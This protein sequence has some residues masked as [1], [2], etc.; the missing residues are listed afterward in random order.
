ML[1]KA[2]SD[3]WK[4]EFHAPTLLRI[5]KEIAAG[6]LNDPVGYAYMKLEQLGFLED[7]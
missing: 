2:R 3:K 6:E 1:S 5:L 4:T 7:K